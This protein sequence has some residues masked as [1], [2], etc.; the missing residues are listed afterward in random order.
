LMGVL[1]GKMALFL[2]L[3]GFEL[4]LFFVGIAI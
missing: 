2:G 3:I 4:G 1:V